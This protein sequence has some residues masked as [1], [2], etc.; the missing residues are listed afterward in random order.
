MSRTQSF[1]LIA[2]LLVVGA[3]AV[4]FVWHPWRNSAEDKNRIGP[5]VSR[6]YQTPQTILIQVTYAGANAQTVAETV[7]APIEKEVNGV[8][9]MVAMTSHCANDGSYRLQITFELGTD[10]DIA[11]VVVQNR[12]SLAIP[13]LP[14]P[15]RQE[16]IWVRKKSPDPLVLVS[17]TCPDNR[18]D[19]L[20]LSNYAKI[21]INDELARVPG[22][23]DVSLMGKRE[24]RL[25]VYLDPDRL[26]ARELTVADVTAA[27]KAQNVQVAAGTIGAP[28]VP[29]GQAFQLTLNTLGRL[30]EPEQFEGLIL[31]TGLESQIVRLRDVAR[32]E[33]ARDESSNSLAILNGKPA[34]VVCL[35]PLPNAKPSDVSKA[36]A[37]KLAE[38][39]GQL[40]DGLDLAAPFDFAANLDH[41][42]SA[43]TPE[44]LV[45]DIELPESASAERSAKIVEHA[46]AVLRKSPGVQDVLGLS[47]HPFLFAHNGPC[48]IV[49]LAPKNQRELNRE[50]I[51]ETV[52]GLLRE[53][54]PEAMFRVSSPSTADDFPVY[55]YPIDLTIE[56]RGLHGN[57]WLREHAEAIAEK[58][59]KSAK[60]TDVSISA[61]QRRAPMVAIDVDR[62][63][64]T[65]L[66][67]DVDDVFTTIQA[68]LRA[69]GK[70]D[71]HHFG[72][73][74]QI[75]VRVDERFRDQAS[76]LK[77]LKVKNKQGQAVPLGTV[78]QVREVTGPTMIER[79]NMYPSVRITANLTTGV[80]LS[81]ATAL[82]EKVARD[83]V[84]VKGTGLIWRGR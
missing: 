11:Q 44:H 71:M 12:I 77:T 7:A 51:V 84:G 48:L 13:V 17:L 41:P 23:G 59:T 70:K 65:V 20:Y 66:G 3:G 56:D 39:R 37:D 58:M 6:P 62:D 29:K 40:P 27:L 72:R 54:I 76:A 75:I 63:K 25:Q 8:E 9:H 26:A 64:C 19:D 67:I 32:V 18:F 49:R 83:E 43:T 73:T 28:A 46:V 57:E 47:E 4:I 69:H 79:H 82:C 78:T 2:T 33:L 53:Q 34:V 10:L 5:S 50:K 16:G 35:Y 31:K 38:L 1:L 42:D 74:W 36:V 68:A 52:R 15:I 14:D 81:D 55:G 80:V 24:Y 30:A 60:F 22:V 61:T 45:I 21:Q